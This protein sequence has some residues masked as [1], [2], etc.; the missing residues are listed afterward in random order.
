[1]SK[2]LDLLKLQ[3]QIPLA[4]WRSRAENFDMIEQVSGIPL[5]KSSLDE[6]SVTRCCGLWL[7]LLGLLSFKPACLR[8]SIIYTELLR[9]HGHD[10]RI[11]L[12]ARK[13]GEN[14]RGHSW[15]EVE[16]RKITFSPEGYQ[17]LWGSDGDNH[18]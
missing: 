9:R 18:G 15:V 14:M 13:N 4:V 3:A 16:G 5:G 2:P 7:S 10:A 17:I 12:G 8:R 6:K 11:M 1:M